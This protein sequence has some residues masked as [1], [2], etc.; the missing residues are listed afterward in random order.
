MAAIAVVTAAAANADVISS[1]AFTSLTGGSANYGPSPFA[2]ITT[3]PNATYTGLIRGSGVGSSTGSGAAG[4]WGGN[5][6]LSTGQ[7]AAI[8]ASEYVSFTITPDAGYEVSFSSIDAYNVRRS[9]SGATTGIWQYQIGSGAF[10]DIGSAI[11]WGSV[12]SNAGNLQSAINLGGISALQSVTEAVTFRVVL[13]GGTNATGT[14]YFNGHANGGSLPLTVNGSITAVPEPHEYA[15]AVAGLLTL[16][17][18]ARRRR[19]LRAEA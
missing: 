16:L 19:A 7:A 8:A 4:A 5:D 11:T 12:T 13:W 2:A 15:V 14:W 10:V 6:T 3:A 18:V 9:A 1:W 17:V